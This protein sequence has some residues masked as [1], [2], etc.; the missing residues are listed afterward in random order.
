[1]RMSRTA[2]LVAALSLAATTAP[3]SAKTTP[4]ATFPEA[5]AAGETLT[6]TVRVPPRTKAGRAVLQQRA[7]RRWRTRVTARVDRRTRRIR[8]RWRPATSAARVTLRVALRRGERTLSVTRTRRVAIE[9]PAAAAPGALPVQRTPDAAPAPSPSPPPNPLAGRR[10]HLNLDSPAVALARDLRAA[11][12]HA[13]AALADKLATTPTALWLADWTGEDPGPVVRQYVAAARAAGA[14][15]LFAVYR[16]P[17]RDCGHFSGGGAAG[18]AAYRAWIDALHRAL[19]GPAALVI[20]P[21]ALALLGCR[22][23]ADQ[24]ATL[25]LIRYAAAMLSR[26]PA[27]TIYLDAGNSSWHPEALMAMRLRAAGVDLVRGFS[28]NVS[29]YRW[30]A[31]ELAYGSRLAGALGGD[32]H[33]VVD[34]SRNGRG[35]TPDGHFC[36]PPGRALG[37]RPTTDTGTPRADALLWVKA[38]GESD[39]PCNGGPPAGHFWPEGALALARAAAW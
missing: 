15:P 1:M 5:V 32:A 16:I 7:G 17:G 30:T 9:R 29:N 10:I 4:R 37:T 38:P 19:T 28:L 11:G 22:T 34:T 24:Q 25:D 27:R 8:L 12:R 31:D 18:A 33:F 2:L 20:E 13:D 39:G 14:L 6:V 21:D 26:D 3:A 35:A 36:N 23:P